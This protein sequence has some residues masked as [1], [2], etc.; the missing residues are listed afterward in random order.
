MLDAMWRRR[1]GD[2]HQRALLIG[3]VTAA[4]FS[5]HCGDAGQGNGDPPSE[6]LA[7]C[8]A[9]TSVG[10]APQTIEDVTALINA[11]ANEHG[12]TVELPCFVASL[13]RP[14]GA[15]TSS[16]FISAQPAEGKRSPRMFLWS[17]A[18]VMSVVPEG[19]GAN[20]L[21]LGFETTPTRSIK[22]EIEFP[23]TA[24]LSRSAPY[25][26]ILGEPLSKCAACHANEEP[27]TSVTWAKALE[28]EVL[29]PSR[30]DEVD[31]GSVDQE[32]KACNKAAEP[33][34]CALLGA[35]FDQGGIHAR[36]FAQEART[37]YG[38]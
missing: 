18:L 12:G 36:A 8:H 19:I 35:V 30:F 2:W 20:L 27:V 17:G 25:D 24:P 22:A 32:S 7:L 38:D 3:A 37:L 5:A 21:E 4:I 26:R 34:R 16:G 11:L 23:V 29:R 33:Q 6:D 1:S 10:G 14:L 28:S 13:T 31:L 15:A 9:P